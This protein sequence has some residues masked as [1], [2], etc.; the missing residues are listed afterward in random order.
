MSGDRRLTLAIVADG[1]NLPAQVDYRPQ[2]AT[3]SV[4]GTGPAADAVAIADQEA[5]Y[6][7]RKG[8]QTKVS[9]RDAL[10]GEAGSTAKEGGV[11]APMHGKVLAVL[12]QKGDTV[13]RGQRL[14]II[15][16][17]KMEHTLTAPVEG[18]VVEIAV[19]KD[20]QVAEG[21]MLILIAPSD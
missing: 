5:I 21:A 13:R 12:V 10:L 1:E 18:T 7:L 15:E 9:R 2:G 19:E 14:A 6:V 16:A 3:V 4:N 8:R 20:A 17:M 11:R